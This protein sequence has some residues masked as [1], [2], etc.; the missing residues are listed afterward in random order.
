MHTHAH[1][2]AYSPPGYPQADCTYSDAHPAADYSPLCSACKGS[3]T[4]RK[5]RKVTHTHTHMRACIFNQLVAPNIY[6][7][8][9]SHPNPQR[10][11]LMHTHSHT[12]SH[13]HMHKNITPYVPHSQTHP[14]PA[15]LTSSFSVSLS[16]AE[17]VGARRSLNVKSLSFITVLGSWGWFTRAGHESFFSASCV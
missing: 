13:T 7:P 12:H 9:H 4:G 6:K 17:V 15:T 2:Y 14:T 16:L 3:R 1:S 11:N 5:K 10:Y 8:S